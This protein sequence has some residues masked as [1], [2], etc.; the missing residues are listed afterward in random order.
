MLRLDH[1]PSELLPLFI[2]FS[3]NQLCWVTDS[4]YSELPLARRRRPRIISTTPIATAV[5]P[6]IGDSG[7]CFF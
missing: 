2:L 3:S 1:Y 7:I 6:A 5:A 4:T